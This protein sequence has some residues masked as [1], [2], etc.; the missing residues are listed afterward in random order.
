M[1]VVHNPDGIITKEGILLIK[2]TTDKLSQTI[3]IAQVLSLTNYPI[4]Q[5]EEDDLYFDQ[6]ER[7]SKNPHDF[8]KLVLNS[9]EIFGQFI[10]KDMTTALVVARLTPHFEK[11]P[12]YKKSTF[13]FGCKRFMARIFL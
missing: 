11:I 9:P 13:Y 5:T 3:S 8:K 1:V 4:I 7:K 6:I 10:D 2:E 12:N